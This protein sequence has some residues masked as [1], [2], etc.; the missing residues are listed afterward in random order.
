MNMFHPLHALF[1]LL[2]QVQIEK[3]VKKQPGLEGP[4]EI[5]IA[6]Y[7]NKSIQISLIFGI[8]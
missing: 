1:L 3:S 6:L 7:G 4:R 2:G 5:G 8:F